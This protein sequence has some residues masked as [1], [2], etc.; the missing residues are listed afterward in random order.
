MYFELH[1]GYESQ[2]WWRQNPMPRF[3]DASSPYYIFESEDLGLQGLT[4]GASL[5]F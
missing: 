2:Y 4:L 5:D 1:A 3:I